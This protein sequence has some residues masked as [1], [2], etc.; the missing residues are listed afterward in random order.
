MSNKWKMLQ[1][2]E[3]QAQNRDLRIEAYVSERINRNPIIAAIYART[4]ALD[5]K[6]GVNLRTKVCNCW[7]YCREEC[8]KVEFI[9]VD[10]Y[11][12]REKTGKSSFESMIRKANKGDFDAIVFCNLDRF[13]CS[14]LSVSWKNR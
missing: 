13:D 5:R 2:K 10:R 11:E 6:F 1:I 7:S 12:T 9:F 3:N 8:W 4:N 14:V